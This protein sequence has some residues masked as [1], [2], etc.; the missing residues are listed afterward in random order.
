MEINNALVQDYVDKVCALLEI[1]PPK[2][3]Y[4]REIPVSKSALAALSADGTELLLRSLY[5]DAR[6]LFTAVAH[7]LRH[8]YQIKQKTFSL[9]YNR[10]ELALEEYNMQPA[11]IDANAFSVVVMHNFFGVTPTFEAL[12]LYIRDKIKAQALIIVKELDCK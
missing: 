12:P 10:I 1:V 4:C 11:E 8:A 7:E 3:T 2:I 6:D 5:L 9:D